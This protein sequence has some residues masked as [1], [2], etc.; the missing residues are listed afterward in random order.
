MS[1]VA[2]DPVAS[3]PSAPQMVR[4]FHTNPGAGPL[5]HGEYNLPKGGSL[6]VPQDVADIWLTHQA[7]G[8]PVCELMPTDATTGGVA[9]QLEEARKAAAALAEENAEILESNDRLQQRLEEL[10]KMLAD[11][12]AQAER[13]P[14]IADLPGSTPSP[15]ELR[16]AEVEKAAVVPA[17]E[18]A[19]TTKAKTTPSEKK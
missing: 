11:A 18:A 19:K 3:A 7:F 15:E 9:T 8:A 1:N 4:I 6:V 16:A 12:R 13:K 14:T 17:P 5:Q 10:S 2:K